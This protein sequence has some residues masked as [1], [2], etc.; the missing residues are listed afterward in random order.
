MIITDF[1]ANLKSKIEGETLIE[2]GS[3]FHNYAALAVKDDRAE[4]VLQ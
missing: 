4:L 3:E 2:F 1:M